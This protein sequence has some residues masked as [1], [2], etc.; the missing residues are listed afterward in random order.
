MGRRLLPRLGL[1]AFLALANGPDE[2]FDLG[3][4]HFSEPLVERE[5]VFPRHVH[6]KTRKVFVKPFP[7]QRYPALFELASNAREGVLERAH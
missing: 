1:F 2:F 3:F 7:S 6:R 5:T 4:D